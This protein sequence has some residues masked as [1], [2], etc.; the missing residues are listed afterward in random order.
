MSEL[1]TL[2]GMKCPEVA[3]FARLNMYYVVTSYYVG[4]GYSQK[5]SNTTSRSRIKRGVKLLLK[6][7]SSFPRVKPAAVTAAPAASENSRYSHS[8][9]V[10]RLIQRRP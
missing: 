10:G 8:C 4:V 6:A 2:H 5:G 7:E 9:V 3:F 1:K